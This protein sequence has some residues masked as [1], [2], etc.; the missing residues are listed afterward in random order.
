M[1][2]LF[3]RRSFDWR[4]L[5]V[6]VGLVVVNNLLLSRL[7][8]LLPGVGDWNWVGKVL[9]LGGTLAIASL[10]FFLT[11]LVPSTDI[12]SARGVVGTLGRCRIR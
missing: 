10:P 8:G 7:Y 2:G 1:L 9:A 11:L 4:W 6:A 5:L 12:G 3:Q